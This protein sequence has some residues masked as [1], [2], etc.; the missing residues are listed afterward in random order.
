MGAP[1]CALRA[2]DASEDAKSFEG[3]FAQA[4]QPNASTNAEK[5][6]IADL[7]ANTDL[8]RDGEVWP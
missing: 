1:A 6:F 4:L 7:V 3:W 5:R 8:R 2:K